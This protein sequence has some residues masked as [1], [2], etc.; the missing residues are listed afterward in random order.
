M[1]EEG[2]Q[3]Q[4]ATR[5]NQIY[6]FISSPG[7]EHIRNIIL[8]KIIEF[9]SNDIIN[10]KKGE[11]EA[12]VIAAQHVKAAL[13]DILGEIEGVKDTKKYEQELLTKKFDNESYI[14]NLGEEES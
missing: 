1:S 9:D 14:L 4:E 13:K 3:Q 11:V 7:W 5:I 6:D 12:Q 2:K 10:I 8:N